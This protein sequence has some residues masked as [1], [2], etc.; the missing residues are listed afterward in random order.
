MTRSMRRRLGMLVRTI[1]AWSVILLIN[2]PLLWMISSSLKNDRENNSLPLTILPREIELGNYARVLTGDFWMWALN[3]LIVA[4][5]TVVLVIVVATLAA[6]SLTRYTYRGRNALASVVLFTYLFPPVLMLVP[7]FLIITHL[8][9]SNTRLALILAT[10]TFALPFALWLLRSYFLSVTMDTEEAAMI[11]GASRFQAFFEIVIPQVSPG[12]ISTAIFTFIIAWDEYLFASVFI[13]SPE[14]KT[15]PIG[16]AGY[17][18]E[19]TAEWGILMAASVAA[20]VPVLILFAF[21]QRRLLPDLNAGS[22]K[23]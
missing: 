15:L 20:A 17:A 5:G 9:L 16:I 22:T 19:L 8:G 2:F 7:I 13:S 1:L 21:L 4:S 11:D 3:S 18:N 6:Y 12:V 10:T 14:R 23:A